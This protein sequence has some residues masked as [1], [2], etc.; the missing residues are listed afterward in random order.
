[1]PALGC[2]IAELQE[3]IRRVWW[4][5]DLAGALKAKEQEINDQTIVLENEGRELQTADHA[6]S[7]CV[8]HVLVV[9]LNIVL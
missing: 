1:M 5:G 6:V 3:V 9:E 4:T 2:A 8:I 7:V